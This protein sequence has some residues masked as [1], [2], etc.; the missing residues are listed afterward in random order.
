VFRGP[1]RK[2][3]FAQNLSKNIKKIEKFFRKK[4]Q[5]K[6]IP[7]S[8]KTVSF[9]QLSG[10]IKFRKETYHKIVYSASNEPI[11]IQFR[12]PVKFGPL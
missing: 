4:F 6:I 9:L 1:L 11:Y 8:I 7:K 12:Q 5:E 10:K 3:T 2:Q